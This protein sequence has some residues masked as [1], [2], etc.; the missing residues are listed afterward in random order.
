MRPLSLLSACL[1]LA[2]GTALASLD[3]VQVGDE[4]TKY[5]LQD[6]KT[7]K[8]LGTFWDR[9]NDS[10]DY[11]FESSIVPDFLWSSDRGYV[12][13]TAGAAR[14]RAV[15]LYRVTGNSLQEIPVPQ[16][17]SSQ[18]AAIDAIDAAASGTDAVR[19][20]PDG[21]LLLRFWADGEVHDENEKQKTAQ[22][23]A[24]LEIRGTSAAIV[25]TSTEEPST[26]PE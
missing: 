11:G 10:S 22:V 1:L 16:L 17:T 24:D 20:Q 26:A 19:W 15:S 7:G 21:T 12:A 14:S 6:T 4:G 2:A 9:E 8:V 25:G 3:I 5:V 23:W 13:V 18:A